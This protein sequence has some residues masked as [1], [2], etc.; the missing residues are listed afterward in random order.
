MAK[1]TKIWKFRILFALG[2]FMIVAGSTAPVFLLPAIIPKADLIYCFAICWL[3]R[4]P[5]YVL[6]IFV[7]AATV[8]SELLMLNSPGLW[9]A[10]MLLLCEY[11]RLNDERIRRL[12][13]WLEWALAAF[14]FTLAQVGYH[15]ILVIVFQPAAPARAIAFYAAVTALYYPIVVL[16]SNWVFRVTKP[17]LSEI[18]LFHTQ[19]QENEI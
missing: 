13:F 2:L 4:R 3:I 18:V 12:P 10:I 19:S 8:F 14:L 6:T 5:Q 1:A 16:V 9:S 7:L 11:F 15:L 17:S